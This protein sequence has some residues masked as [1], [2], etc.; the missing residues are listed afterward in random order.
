MDEAG[1]LA[2][3]GDRFEGDVQ[4]VLAGGQ[5]GEVDVV[6]PADAGGAQ[7]GAGLGDV[8]PHVAGAGAADEAAVEIQAH[9]H[10]A[11]RGSTF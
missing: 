11:A 3:G 2:G 8:L 9:P 5:G 4:T 6:P 1:G 7:F 10:G